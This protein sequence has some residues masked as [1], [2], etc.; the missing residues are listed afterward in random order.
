VRGEND[1]AYLKK[2]YEALSSH[3]CFKGMQFSDDRR[4]IAQWLPLMMEGRHPKERIAATRMAT[5]TDINFGALTNLLIDSLKGKDGVGIHYLQRV[6]DL[7]RTRSSWELDIKDEKTGE[8]KQVNAN[9]VF[10]GA[11]GGSLPLL[12]K[13]DIPEAAGYA[14]FPVS[15]IWL[16]CDRSDL[17]EMHIAKVYGKAPVGSPPMSVPH[18]DLR[19]IGEQE[20]LLFGPFAGFSSKFLKH[21]SLLDL[22]TSIDPENIIPLLAVGK[23][24]LSLERYL[25][26]QIFESP[27]ERFAALQEF[28]PTAKEEDWYLEVAGQRVQIVKKDKQHGGV[29]QFGTEVVSAAD[30]SLAALLGASPGASVS[31]RIMLNILEKCFGEQLQNGWR[32][33]LKL[34]IPSYGRS[35]IEDAALCDNVRDETAAVLNLCADPQFGPVGF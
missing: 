17:T 4:K 8:H 32:E 19:H 30:G 21:G 13:S 12:Q 1:V 20:S 26:G 23:D 7:K 11:G 16:R 27:R 24:N 10:I 3:H 22:F 6:Q 35:L 34:M 14:G 5:G 25:I 31:V 2:R 18:L 15:G 9:F 33:R 29:L 28:F